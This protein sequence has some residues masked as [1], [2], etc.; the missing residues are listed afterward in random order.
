MKIYREALD[1]K[2]SRE[3][4]AN[5][6][7]QDLW[8]LEDLQDQKAPR[9]TLEPQASLEALVSLVSQV[10]RVNLASLEMMA[11][12]E[13]LDQLGTLAREEKWDCK[14]HQENRFDTF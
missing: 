2:E 9:V 14:V 11:S 4:K 3:N 13:I 6:D 8:A 10:L 7:Q 1:L 12:L 5:L